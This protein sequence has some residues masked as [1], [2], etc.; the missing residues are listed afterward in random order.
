MAVAGGGVVTVPESTDRTEHVVTV[1]W[2]RPVRDRQRHDGG[3][4]A[5]VSRG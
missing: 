3:R 2:E 5:E 1:V 4:F